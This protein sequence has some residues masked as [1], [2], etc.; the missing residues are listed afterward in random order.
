MIKFWI[1]SSLLLTSS[2]MNL[3]ML[4]YISTTLSLVRYILILICLFLHA[5]IYVVWVLIWHLDNLIF[6]CLTHVNMLICDFFIC[7]SVLM[8]SLMLNGMTIIIISVD[9]DFSMNCS[10]KSFSRCSFI[11]NASSIMTL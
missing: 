10:L 3:C 6:S 2:C 1:Y 11:D 8:A 9:F 7:T 5:M 4:Q